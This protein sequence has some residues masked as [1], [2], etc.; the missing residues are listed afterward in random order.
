MGYDYDNIA[1]FL[2]SCST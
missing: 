2:V 1:Q